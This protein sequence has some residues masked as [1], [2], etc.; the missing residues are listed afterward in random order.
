METV[1]IIVYIVI[2]LILGSLVLAFIGGWDP[3]QTYDGLKRAMGGGDTANA[4]EKIESDRLPA[5]VL[6]F[7]DACGFGTTTMEKNIYVTDSAALSK[8]TLFSYY[9][10]A[11]L[12]RS[13]QSNE[14]GCGTREDVIFAGT[15]GP[16]LLHLKCDEAT[17]RLIITS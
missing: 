11:S 5:A 10:A 15:T 13:I 2:A 12:C 1:E 4:Y 3:K 16:V 17:Q 8:S 6:S 14:S 9:K 7:W